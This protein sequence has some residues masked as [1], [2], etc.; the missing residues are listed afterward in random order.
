VN[1]PWTDIL[2]A[3]RGLLFAITITACLAP[4]VR[5]DEYTKQTYLTFSGPVQLPG[6][7]LPAG[8][9]QFKL[10]DPESG[11][12]ALQVW[13][14]DGARL[15]TTLDTAHHPRPADDTDRRTGCDVHREQNR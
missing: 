1:E 13:D 6:I 11:R 14:K 5:G 2:R 3:L 4:G 9:Y 15:F 12:R 7:V 8:T 10:A